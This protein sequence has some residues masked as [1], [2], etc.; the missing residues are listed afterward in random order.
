MADIGLAVAGLSALLLLPWIGA[1]LC[2][3]SDVLSPILLFTFYVFIGYLLPISSFLAGIDPV[4]ISWTN[5]YGDFERSLPRA[6]WITIAGVM[7]FYAGYAVTRDLLPETR[8]QVFGHLPR[9]RDDRL[10]SLGILYTASG[11]ALFSLGVALIGGPSELMFGLSSRVTLSAG[12]N[13]FFYAINLL[14]VVSLVWWVRALSEQRLPSAAF[15]PY[16]ASAVALAALQGSKVILFVFTLAMTLVYHVIRRRV[17][18][19][20]LALLVVVFLPAVSMYTIYVREYVV[21]GELSSIDASDSWLS[22]LATVV[23]REF[24]GNFVQLQA[25]TLI[26]DRMPDVLEFQNG[27]TLLAMLTIAVPS[28]WYPEKYLTAPGVFTLAIDPDRWV[29]EGTTLPPGLIG[30]MYMN[31]GTTGVVLGLFGFGAAFGWIRRA[32]K[33]RSRDPVIVALYA[34]AVAMMAHYV[35]GEAVSPTV[36]LLIF[37]LPMIVLLGVGLAEQRPARAGERAMDSAVGESAS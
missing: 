6:L 28:S 1:I 22:L 16:T 8:R 31:F 7:G 24:A 3:R 2:R 10:L 30:E 9:W 35:R 15:W 11:L 14:L 20:K 4:T 29:R 23:T 37:A 5:V 13:Y 27:R 32:V 26:V 21:L 19:A 34:L 33:G 18:M 36:L 25:L 17:S 12:L